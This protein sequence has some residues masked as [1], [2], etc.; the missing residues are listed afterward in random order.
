M[1]EIH[2][3][4]FFFFLIKLVTSLLNRSLEPKTSSQEARWLDHQTE[5]KISIHLN[6]FFF[7]Y[8]NDIIAT[9]KPG[10]ET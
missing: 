9:Y 6:F 8:V 4:L 3:E 5:A 1:L 7:F 10:F 2:Y